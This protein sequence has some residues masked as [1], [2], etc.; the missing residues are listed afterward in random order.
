MKDGTPGLDHQPL[1]LRGSGA[2]RQKTLRLLLVHHQET[3]KETD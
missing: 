2:R 1:A 3:T